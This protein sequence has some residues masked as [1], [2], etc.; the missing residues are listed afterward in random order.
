MS[1][2][3]GVD[4]GQAQDPT[5]LVLL[6][7]TGDRHEVGWAEKLPIGTPY[8]EGVRE[9]AAMADQASQLDGTPCPIVVDYTGVGRP[10]V[11][12]LRNSTTQDVVPVT[13]T[14]GGRSTLVDGSWR[15][16]KQELISSLQVV[17]EQHRIASACVCD[18]ARDL[19]H[20]LRTYRY[21]MTPSGGITYGGPGGHGDDLVSALA[22]A[23]WWAERPRRGVRMRFRP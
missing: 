13:T 4:V 21:E 14:S 7:T 20:E 11:E 8:G 17:F 3:L 16:P 1:L 2:I 18:G 6:G 19:E 22:L 23:A 15:V 9:M 10:V 12:L 5:A